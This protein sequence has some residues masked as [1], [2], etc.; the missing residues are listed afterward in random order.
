MWVYEEKVDGRNL[1]EIINT[2]HVNVKYLPGV[3]LPENVVAVPD[4]PEVAK[5]ATILIFVL[6][7]QFLGRLIPQVGLTPVFTSGV[8]PSL[9]S[10]SRRSNQF[11]DPMPRQSVSSRESI[12]MMKVLFSLVTSSH[13]DW[14][15]I[16]LF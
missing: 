4:L 13:L 15:L 10:C 2:D 1:T 9:A 7:H 16:A 5:D 11:F 8:S 12:S 6:P 3:T 14:G